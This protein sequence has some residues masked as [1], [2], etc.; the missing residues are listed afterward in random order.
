MLYGFL[1]FFLWMSCVFV[2]F[3]AH[4]PPFTSLAYARGGDRSCRRIGTG[5]AGATPW[6]ASPVNCRPRFCVGGG[7]A[8]GGAGGCGSSSP[9]RMK[10]LTSRQTPRSDK[11]L[12]DGER[13]GDLLLPNMTH[14][15]HFR[16][17]VLAHNILQVLHTQHQPT[18]CFCPQLDAAPRPSA[19]FK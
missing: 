9:Q 12:A 10:T 15:Q 11:H 7:I 14:S 1:W 6:A 8:M 19:R 3:T 2:L 5:G 13:L 18:T 17:Q 4:S 16:L